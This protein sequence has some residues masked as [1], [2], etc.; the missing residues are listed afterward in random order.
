MVI[1]R[2]EIWAD[3]M[4]PDYQSEE[5]NVSNTESGKQRPTDTVGVELAGESMTE[6][7]ELRDSLCALPDVT[8]H[9]KEPLLPLDSPPASAVGSDATLVMVGGDERAALRC[10]RRRAAVVPRPSLIA[11]LRDR[12]AGMMRRILKSGVNDL[13]FFPLDPAPATRAFLQ[14]ANARERSAAGDSRKGVC[15][16]Q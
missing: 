5:L 6:L 15:R 13:L 3:R 7:R 1:A 2:T 10:L 14:I 8:I 9:V 16:H 4:K 11:V 12:S